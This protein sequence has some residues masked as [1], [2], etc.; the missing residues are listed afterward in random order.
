MLFE[1]VVFTGENLEF[2]FGSFEEREEFFEV[3]NFVV[4]FDVENSKV[5]LRKITHLVVYHLTFK[6]TF[7]LKN[8]EIQRKRI[9]VLCQK[10]C[11]FSYLRLNR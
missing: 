6:H 11:I 2:F 1:G 5:T 8:F 9:L 7:F 10:I 3:E 4:V